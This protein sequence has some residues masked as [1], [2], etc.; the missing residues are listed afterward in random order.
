MTDVKSSYGDTFLTGK[1]QYEETVDKVAG[2]SSLGT[3][4]QKTESPSSLLNDSLIGVG[5]T[6]EVPGAD[7]LTFSRDETAKKEE[8]KGIVDF[9]VVWN[10]N[11]PDNLQTLAD[12]K[13]IFSFQLPKMPKEYI[14]RLV[15]NRN[16][17]SLCI[18][19][20]E[21]K[22]R[23]KVIGGICFR[24]FHSQKFAEIVFC[25]ITSDEQVKGYGTRIMNHLKEHV[26]QEGIEYFLTYAD[27]YAIGYF[28]KQGF[29]RQISMDREQWFGFIKD[30]DG[31]TL[32]ECRINCKVNYL[33]IP[34]MIK[35]QRESVY[36]KIKTVSNSHSVYNGL[37]AFQEGLPSIDIQFIPGVKEAGWKATTRSTRLHFDNRP[38]PLKELTAKLHQILKNLKKLK[39][40][41]PFL[42]KI[43]GTIVRDYYDVIKEPMD[44]GT[45]EERL[46]TY[47]YKTVEMFTYD[48]MLVVDNCRTYNDKGTNYYQSA[49][50]TEALFH[51]L[52]K[53]FELSVKK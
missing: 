53:R 27:N 31:G 38:S 22:A 42:H 21:G 48:F 40:A 30:Y 9:E 33:N 5:T 28:K 44:F 12:V 34:G 8:D 35:A 52:M 15:Y 39:D 24:P 7:L 11:K 47:Y 45:M 3:K 1:R 50:K 23:K 17:R 20:D 43:D 32:M 19:K 41:W 49:D 29:S 6:E 10:D 4:Q 13:N 2:S 14:S 51:E 25:A 26:K 18:M 16:H 36:E 46:N 37:T